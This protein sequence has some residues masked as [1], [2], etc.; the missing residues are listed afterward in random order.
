MHL[1]KWIR[2]NSTKIMVFVVIFSM[3]S[4]VIGYTGLQIFFSFFS[5]QGN[6]VVATYGQGQKLRARDF[7]SAQNEL[8]FLRALAGPQI[9][10]SQNQLGP[11]GYLLGYLLFPDDPTFASL[12]AQLQRAAKEGQLPVSQKV[13]SAFFEQRLSADETWLLLKREAHQTGCVF[14]RPNAQNLLVQIA[15]QINS[16]NPAIVIQNLM[17][18][19]HMTEQQMADALAELLTVAFYV[20]S[21]LD[22]QPVTL[23]EIQALVATRQQ[24]LTAAL[25]RIP[26]SWFIQKDQP[27]EDAELQKQFEAYKHV[28]AGQVSAEN[29][30]GFGY[31]LPARVQ[32]EYMV[33]RIEDIRARIEQPSQEQMEEYYSRN[34]QQFEYQEPADPAKPEGEKITKVRSFAETLP[35]IRRALEEERIGRLG[36]QW[37]NQAKAELEKGFGGLH[38]ESATFEQLQAAAGDYDKVAA[39]VGQALQI[40]AIVGK[41]GYLSAVDFAS[42]PM[43]QMMRLIQ[44]QNVVMLSELALNVVMDPGQAPRFA[45][46]PRV[47]P[48]ENIGPM[49]TGFFDE[50]ARQFVRL[51]VMVRVVDFKPQETPSSIDVVYPKHTIQLTPQTLNEQAKG[52][53][54]LKD[55]VADD[56]RLLRAMETAQQ[57]AQ[58]LA[59]MVSAEGWDKAL[60]TFNQQ[61][62]E[63]AIDGA[64]SMRDLDS[65]PLMTAMEQA[66]VQAAIASGSPSAMY[67]RERLNENALRQ[68]LFG[69]LADQTTELT[70]TAKVVVCE[71]MQAAYVVRSV[72]L[73]PATEKDW[74]EHK[75]NTAFQTARI[76]EIEAALIFLNPGHI[77]QR[78]NYHRKEREFIA[79]QQIELPD[80]GV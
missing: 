39:Q 58:Q 1:A 56:V 45:G 26:A 77:Q 5:Q 66:M 65:Q 71:P 13:V 31:Q 11:A 36:N 40:P 19:F 37:F 23:N 18:Q 63:Q 15:K 53:F 2:K 48:W 67:L 79:P 4:F 30:Y 3:V 34:R 73:S 6:V 8:Q 16:D 33:V 43:L 42:D 7:L 41:T 62:K 28:L 80:E 52:Y 47:R 68:K 61:L 49:N 12:P 51:M 74:L 22:N 46:M 50:A 35:Q 60:E 75:T 20:S 72:K 54:S 25:A 32:L 78:M 76:T 55:R 14:P 21:V 24:K 57:K 10:M 69:L 59:Q 44:G 70:E 9:L 27:V 64:V 38:I 17:A 29:P